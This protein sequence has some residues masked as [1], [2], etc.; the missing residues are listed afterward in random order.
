VPQV[1]NPP[2]AQVVSPPPPAA[3]PA[4]TKVEE[5]AK[6]K[7]DA[8]PISAQ[9]GRVMVNVGLGDRTLTMLLDTGADS[10]VITGSTADGLVR[11]G[12]ARWAGMESFSMADGTMRDIQT[13]TV[14]EVKVGNHVVRNVKAGV[15]AT[16]THMLLGMSVLQAIG[17]FLLDTRNQ[18]LVFMPAEASL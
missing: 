15:V 3:P 2:P 6:P 16:G 12:H 11:A 13:V 9:N 4:L 17:P 5:P 8:I 10:L 18:Q 7:R 1:V 14:F